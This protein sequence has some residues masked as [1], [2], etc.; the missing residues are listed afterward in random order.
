MI[1][2]LI[3][4]YS[5]AGFIKEEVITMENYWTEKQ[6]ANL[7]YFNGRLPV[8]LKDELL[9]GKFVVVHEEKIKGSFDT[10]ESALRSAV[11]QFPADEYVIQQVISD[12]DTI[13][14]LFSASRVA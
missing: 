11:A 12:A 7:K 3:V 2:F 13:S 14:F 5:L 1:Y 10:F 8:I 4:T 9:A 6:L